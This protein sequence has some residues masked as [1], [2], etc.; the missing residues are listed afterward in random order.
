MKLETVI[1]FENHARKPLPFVLG[2]A[3]VGL[4]LLL[5]V[6][7]GI[8]EPILYEDDSGKTQVVPGYE[9]LVYAGVW[10][11][12][13]GMLSTLAVGYTVI[14]FILLRRWY[15]NRQMENFDSEG[16]NIE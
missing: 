6:G 3:S 11:F 2:V 7:Y 15:Y 10:L 14:S 5:V 8:D 4:A 16:T 1:K 12:M 13:I 9:A